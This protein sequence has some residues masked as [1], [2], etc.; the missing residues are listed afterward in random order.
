M[1][2]ICNLSS[3]SLKERHRVQSVWRAV[4]SFHSVWTVGVLC[5]WLVFMV[6]GQLCQCSPLPGD[7]ILPWKALWRH[8]L[9]F[10]FPV[11]LVTYPRYQECYWSDWS[12]SQLGWTLWKTRNTLSPNKPK[13]DFYQ[14][15]VTTC[16]GC[17]GRPRGCGEGGPNA[18]LLWCKQCVYSQWRKYNPI[19]SPR[20]LPDSRPLSSP[21]VR[22]FM[23]PLPLYVALT[24][25]AFPQPSWE[26]TWRSR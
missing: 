13:G 16:H 2:F 6:F 21:L 14:A 1:H 25:S 9:L 4:R 11:G 5:L 17:A 8:F 23:C 18:G 10:P 20:V 22:G 15:S 3:S 24:A 7:F 26:K 12:A 19:I